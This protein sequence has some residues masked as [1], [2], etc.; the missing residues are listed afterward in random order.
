MTTA[1]KRDL[2]L[3]HFAIMVILVV[4]FRFLPPVGQI[5]ENGMNV[6]GVFLAVLYGWTFCDLLWVSL[7]G[8]IMIGFTGV[9]TFPEFIAAAFGSDTVL[10]MLFLFFF[11]GMIS[12]VGLIDY[13]ANKIISFNFLNGR[14]WMFSTFILIGTYLAA[15]F[16]NM[17]AA[18]IVFWEILFI[19]SE[20]FGFKK[21]DKYP[22]LMILGVAMTCALAGAVMP[23]KPVP[24]VVL[25]TYSEIAGAP[26]DFFKY[27]VFALPITLLIVLFFIL[28]FRFVFRPDLKK[29]VHISIDF[30]DQSK[31]QLNAK[32]KTAIG[33]LIVFI[34]MMVAP[35]LLPDE[36]FLTQILSSLGNTGIIMALLIVMFLLRFDGQPMVTVKQ[37]VPHVNYD[38]WLMMAFVIPFS[39]VF[40]SEA[41]GIR[42]TLVATM[43]PLL[44]GRSEM[45]FI[46]LT[47]C[48]AA[49]LTNLCNNMVIGAIFTTLIVTIGSSMNMDVAPLIA[50]LSMVVNLSFATPAACP[51]LA[52]A[53]ALKDW[54][55]PQDI[56]KYGSLTVVFSLVFLFVIALPW[57]NLVY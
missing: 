10:Y 30:V 34:F 56:Y 6:L 52:M 19:V 29:L 35:S 1:K 16:I 38:V 32:Q 18:A 50:I 26:M 11:T 36:F 42:E 44:N 8:I 37:L 2:R 24:L 21:M 13:I 40:T 7:F 12:E 45:L 9:I 17:F 3:F 57:A 55:R 4:G 54:M 28:I 5:S 43:Q 49:L 39:S 31:L 14:P 25:S 48:I 41:T 20:R 33:F 22:T 53:F 51:N 23:Y 47:M 27:I 46:V 15:A